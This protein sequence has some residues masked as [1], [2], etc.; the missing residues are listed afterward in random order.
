MLRRN[1]MEGVSTAFQQP[2]DET[3]RISNGR[4]A[5]GSKTI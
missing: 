2:R 4:G 3:M 5:G 1:R